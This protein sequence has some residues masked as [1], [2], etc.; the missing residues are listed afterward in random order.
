M[1][2]KLGLRF[3]SDGKGDLRETF[4]PEDVFD[5]MY[6][7]FHSPTYRARYAEFLKIDFPRLPL[8]SD[9]ELFRV[10]CGLGE[11]LVKL[12]L[13]ERYG[14]LIP[15]YPVQGNDMVERVEYLVPKDDSQ[16]RVYINKMQYF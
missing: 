3:V 14:S 15:G 13:M 12:H 6:A 7:L 16:G 10:L 8:T 2:E 4:G 11:R 5:Y 1:E 9:A